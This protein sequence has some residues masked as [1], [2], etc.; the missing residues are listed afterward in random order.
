ME[1]GIRKKNALSLIFLESHGSWYVF[2]GCSEMFLVIWWHLTEKPERIFWPTPITPFH[3]YSAKQVLNGNLHSGFSSNSRG[4]ERL[5]IGQLVP[6]SSAFTGGSVLKNLPANAGVAGD[7]GSVPVL[8]RSPGEGN[9]KSLHY[10]CLENPMD[11]GAW[12]DIVHG[13]TKSQTRLS[14]HAFFL[15][16]VLAFNHVLDMLPSVAFKDCRNL[17]M[18]HLLTFKCWKLRHILKDTM[19]TSLWK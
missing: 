16:S 15:Q 6:F 2:C 8:G 19:S 1:W 13:V 7:V 11:R 5:F 4:W 9:G 14:T 10:S 18:R 12:Q 3:L 17:F